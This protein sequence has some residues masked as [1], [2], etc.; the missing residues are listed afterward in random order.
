MTPAKV[1]SESAD[2]AALEAELAQARAELLQLQTQLS[3]AKEKATSRAGWLVTTPNATFNGVTAGVVFRKG[4][5]FLPATEHGTAT[6]HMLSA[7]FGYKLAFLSDWQENPEVE[8]QVTRSLIDSLV[9]P[10]RR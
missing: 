4:R 1:Q 8:Q 10:D 2:C 5:A 3:E 9:I 7:E 6:A